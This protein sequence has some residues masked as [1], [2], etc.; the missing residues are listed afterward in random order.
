MVMFVTQIQIVHLNGDEAAPELL[1][2]KQNSACIQTSQCITNNWPLFSINESA[3][4]QA[5]A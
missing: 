3:E 4:A 1:N 2:N 5:G